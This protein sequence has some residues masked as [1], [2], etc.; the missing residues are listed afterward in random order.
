MKDKLYAYYKLPK[1]RVEEI[2]KNGLLVM[3]TNVLLDL[4]RLEETSRKDLKK[5]IEFFGDRVWIPYQVALEFHRNRESVVKD[6][7]TTKYKEFDNTVKEQIEGL[8]NV[9]KR[10]QRHPCID[11]SVIEKSIEKFKKEIEGKVEKWR[12]EYPFQIEN[13][14]VLEWVTTTFDGKVGDDYSTSELTAIFKE[15]LVRYKAEVPPGYKDQ[16]DKDKKEAG[17]RYVFGDLIA[18]KSVIQKARQDKKDVIFLT[19]DNKED[20]FEKRKGRTIGPRFELI[21][22]FHNETDRDIIIMSEASF[23]N[24]MNLQTKVKVKD[25]SIEDAKKAVL[26]DAHYDLSKPLSAS[27]PLYYRSLYSHQGLPDLSGLTTPISLSSAVTNSYLSEDFDAYRFWHTLKESEGSSF[28]GVSDYLKLFN[29]KEW[30]GYIP[31]YPSPDVGRY[32]TG[33]DG[34]KNKGKDKGDDEEDTEKVV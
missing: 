9:F 2:W 6:Y 29:K 22:E 1:E 27:W 12:S 26:S 3:D 18:W 17:E 4:Y 21:R 13:D 5:S 28:G 16:F 24:E 15:G 11:Y 23:L 8:L 34:S 20:W 25:S 30:P 10:F 33:D 19:N 32:D 14:K 31:N 7:G